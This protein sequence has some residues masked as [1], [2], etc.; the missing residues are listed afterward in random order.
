MEVARTSFSNGE[1]AWRFVLRPSSFVLRPSCLERASLFTFFV[2]APK[3][4]REVRAKRVP[5][6][7]D[8]GRRTMDEDQTLADPVFL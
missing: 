4:R 2:A 7:K 6:T 8:E 1:G 5:G 3:E